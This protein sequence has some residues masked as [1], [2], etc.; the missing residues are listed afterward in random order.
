MR[1]AYLESP[2]GK[3]LVAS[4][5]DEL[6]LI[7]FST[8]P[9][10]LSGAASGEPKADWEDVSGSGVGPIAELERQLQ[11]YF[12]GR[13]R[14]FDLPLA[15]QGSDFQK[16][17]WRALQTIPYGETVTYSAIAKHIRRPKAVRA[18]GTANGRN[19]LPIL[20]PCH[21]VIGVSGQLTGFGGGLDT[22]RQLLELE[23]AFPGEAAGH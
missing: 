18:V 21:R 14:T 8:G 10:G 1:Y 12:E 16:A 20:I 13:L 22:K 9:K 17:V 5:D 15:P 4:Q 11:A 23:G 7:R 3:L 19:P 2:I 6:R